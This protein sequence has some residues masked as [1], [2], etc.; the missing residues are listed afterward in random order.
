[1]ASTYAFSYTHTSEYF[2]HQCAGLLFRVHEEFKL[3]IPIG[4]QLL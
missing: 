4:A 3:I 1:M 2:M